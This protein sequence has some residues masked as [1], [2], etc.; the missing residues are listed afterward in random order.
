MSTPLTWREYFRTYWPRGIGYI[1]GG[2]LLLG[3]VLIVARPE[4]Y[5]QEPLLYAL[6]PSALASGIGGTLLNYHEVRSY[7][8]MRE[9]SKAGRR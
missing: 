7:L 2:G 5:E 4:L 3:I 1:F 9:Q 6:I 8:K